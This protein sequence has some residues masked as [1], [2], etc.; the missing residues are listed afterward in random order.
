L[1]NNVRYLKAFSIIRQE[2]ERVDMKSSGMT[3]GFQ[4][5]KCLLPATAEH[6]LM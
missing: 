6:Y 1:D 4:P 5:D 3:A 2:I